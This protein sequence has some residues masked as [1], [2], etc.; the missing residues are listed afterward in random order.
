[1]EGRY[2]G[3]A[4]GLG[5]KKG[6]TEHEKV[7]IKG[8][9]KFHIFTNHCVTVFTFRGS[10]FPQC[11]KPISCD[12]LALLSI[13]ISHVCEIKEESDVFLLRIGMYICPQLRMRLENLD[14]NI[15][16]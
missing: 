10:L 8:Y 1:M 4:S 6:I 15:T 16:A 5:E 3:V 12:F 11:A 9:K 13:I 14:W 2:Y 7:L